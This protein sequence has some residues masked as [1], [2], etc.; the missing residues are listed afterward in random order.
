MTHVIF[1]IIQSS[2]SVLAL[3]TLDILHLIDFQRTPLMHEQHNK[4][5]KD[6]VSNYHAIFSILKIAWLY[7]K[8]NINIIIYYIYK[9]YM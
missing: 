9:Y 5:C 1:C 2:W 6:I 4:V 8:Y 3:L 7:F